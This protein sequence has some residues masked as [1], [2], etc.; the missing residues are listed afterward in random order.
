MTIN[1]LI[2][3]GA[4]SSIASFLITVL[5]TRY[6]ISYLP[7]KKMTVVDYHKDGKPP[8]PRPGGPAIIAGISVS[9][10]V[11]FVVTG[12]YAALG[13]LSVTLVSGLIGVIDDLKTLGGVA[14]PALLLI[15]GLPLLILQYFIPGGGVFDPHLYLPLFETPAHI[16]L[17]YPLLILVAIPVVTNTINT[18][19]VLNGVVSGFIIIALVPVICAIILKIA[20]GKDNPVVLLVVLPIMASAIGFFIFHRFPSKIFPGDSGAIALGGA[21][22]TIAIVGGVEI[23]AVIAILPAILN[24]FFFLSSVKRLVEHREL[25]SQPIEMLPDLKMRATMDREAP[26]TL[27]RLIVASKAKSEK[28]IANDIFKL[29]A[30]SA[31]LAIVTA[32][33]TWVITIG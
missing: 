19:D 25:K 28:E 1:G 5:G 4:A 31:A 23:V 12:S 16:P 18:I 20:L 33:L 21:Y 27:M 17:L 32:I 13:V 14:K 26:V 8:I 29:A 11:L 9:E 6:L 2:A 24:S 7:S 22:A 10:F 30:F 15:A 3:F